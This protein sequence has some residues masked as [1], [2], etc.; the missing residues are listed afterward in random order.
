MTNDRVRRLA[1]AALFISVAAGFAHAQGTPATAAFADGRGSV[2]VEALFSWFKSSPTPVPIIS[3]DYID[4]PGTSIL[5]GGGSLDTNPNPGFRVAASYRLDGAWGL[6]AI[7]FYLSSRTTSR[8]VSST[9]NAGSTNLMLPFYDVGRNS[10]N[11]TE[12]SY[13]PEYSGSA[14]ESLSN[15]LGGGE[16]NATWALAPQGPWRSALIG[17]F[18]YLQLREDYAITTSSPYIAPNPADIWQTTDAFN[19]RNR[20][21]GLQFGARAEYDDGPWVGTGFA[22]IALGSMQQTVSVNGYLETND[23]N[24]YGA[25]QTFS[26]GYFALPSN[27]G[28]YSRNTFAIVPEVALSI[29]YRITPAATV[30]VG[31]SFLYAS[32]VARPGEQINRNINPTQT[33]SYGNDPP[34]NPQGPA[35]P[36]FAFNT[37][38]FWAQTLTVGI[39]YRF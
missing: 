1:T 33:V 32:D 31:Y 14:Q 27:I 29:G 15:N 10:E 26:G 23:Y 8:G 21:Y 25:V 30:Y 22:K 39:N 38:D 37:T 18:R 12:I 5:L 35:Q 20:F 4:E 2:S 36:T 6:E 19:A 16:L 17:G 9:G 11:I 34:V 7:G 3:N 28:N 24:G 13:A